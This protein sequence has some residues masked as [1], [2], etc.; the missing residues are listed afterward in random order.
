MSSQPFTALAIGTVATPELQS[1]LANQ[2]TKSALV[3]EAT[4]NFNGR[5][6]TF[7]TR[8]VPVGLESDRTVHVRYMHTAPDG[9][10]EAQKLYWSEGEPPRLLNVVQQSIR[11][12]AD[13]Y[14]NAFGSTPDAVF[15]DPS[16]AYK[17]TLP[18]L[19]S[20]IPEQKQCANSYRRLRL[21]RELNDEGY[22]WVTDT[23]KGRGIVIIPK[24]G[25][26]VR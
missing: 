7:M 20:V 16:S 6:F 14:S 5:V 23:S 8:L 26:E 18:V 13:A 4:Q 19:S 3:L 9:G 2:P 1:L 21:A 17:K 10:K 25:F 24:C 11:M 22:V 15:A 12:T